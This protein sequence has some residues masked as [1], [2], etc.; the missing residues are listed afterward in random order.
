VRAMASGIVA[1][2]DTCDL[3]DRCGAPVLPGLP[4]TARGGVRVP[5]SARAVSDRKADRKDLL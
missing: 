4:S 5:A 1:V 2:L 3:L